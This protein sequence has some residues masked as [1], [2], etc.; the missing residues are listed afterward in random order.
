MK[1]KIIYSFVIFFIFVAV[2]SICLPDEFTFEWDYSYDNI[3]GFRIYSGNMGQF[4]D[5]TWGPQLRDIPIIDNIPPDA[6]TAKGIE[7]GW[8]GQIKKFCFVARAYKGDIESPD[9]NT[10]CKEINNLPLLA[11]SDV[12]GNYDKD[13]EIINISWKQED[14]DRAK[15]WQIYYK[16][17]DGGFQELGKVENSGQ[18]LLD[19]TSPFEAV[20]AG[21]SA[22]VSFL[23]VAYKNYQ[24]YSPNSSEIV[25]TIDR[26]LETELPPVSDFRFKVEVPVQ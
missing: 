25:L 26:T 18:E 19:I 6:R 21:E 9:S 15:F 3:D 4:E 5:G 2:P 7:E 23:V 22:N 8:T 13:Q 14:S 10:V 16:I 24:V 1:H 17:G 12:N 11:P 20:N